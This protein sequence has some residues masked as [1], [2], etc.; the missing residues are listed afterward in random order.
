MTENSNCRWKVKEATCAQSFCEQKFGLLFLD[1]LQLTSERCTATCIIWS[2]TVLHLWL[3]AVY[4]YACDHFGV[5]QHTGEQK[6]YFYFFFRRLECYNHEVLSCSF[7]CL[8]LPYVEGI[9]LISNIDLYCVLAIFNGTGDMCKRWHFYTLNTNGS[10]KSRP[11]SLTH[12]C[13]CMHHST[14][15]CIQRAMSNMWSILLYE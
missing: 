14:Q 9:V 7:T 13:S 11:R 6:L 1:L 15:N 3:I 5:T 4:R 12:W 2:I 8:P 10:N